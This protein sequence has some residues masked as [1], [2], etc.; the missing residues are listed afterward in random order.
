MKKVFVFLFALF[1]VACGPAEP[2][3]LR[4]ATTTS[5]ADSGLLKAILPTFEAANNATVEVI[6]VGTGQ[7]IALGEAG[8]ADVILVHARSREDA[9]L[10]AGHGTERFHVMYND[11]I[12]VGPEDDPAH[13]QDIEL[14]ADALQAIAAAEANFAS[15]GDDSGTHTK[16]QS[17]WE[18][19]GITP[20]PNGRWYHSLGQGM[21]DTLIFANE[22]QDYTL[23]DRG[24][25]LSMRENI[26]NLVVMVGGE[27]ITD[28]ADETLLNPYGVIPV[29]PDKSN[30]INADLA[31]AFV[32][33]LTAVETQEMIAQFG[34]DTFGQPLFYPDSAAW[35]EARGNNK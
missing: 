28:N 30:A 20:D 3:V 17:L 34:V 8:D 11:F 14:V 29:N 33:W 15:R 1:L 25:F 10:E 4:L 31:V 7:A 21:G 35:H 32:E 12:L 19:A 23:T 27:S 5:T 18:K 6:A 26:P 24:T 13:V 2:Q 22:N 9:F 16:E